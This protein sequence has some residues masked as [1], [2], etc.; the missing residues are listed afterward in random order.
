MSVVYR[1]AD[2]TYTEVD[3]FA[4][5][6]S[7]DHDGD[8]G[9]ANQAWPTYVWR[10]DGVVFVPPTVTGGNA[11]YIGT[12]AGFAAADVTGNGALDVYYSAS[13]SDLYHATDLDGDGDWMGTDESWQIWGS[14]S[15]RMND[16]ALVQ[17][18]LPDAEYK[19]GHWVLLQW[20]RS[21]SMS[22]ATRNLQIFTLDQN[23]DLVPGD[24]KIIASYYNGTGDQSLEVMGTSLGSSNSYIGFMPL[25]ALQVPEP[26]TML[27]VGSGILGLVGT[28]RRRFLH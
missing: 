5:R 3:M 21:T 11:N 18:A 8:P 4:D 26:G 9:T 10:E 25:N 15:A 13:A 6:P 12:T 1:H 24:Y 17:V 20:Q 7:W 14:T 27:L 28:L 19:A 23:G 22:Y 2:G 16:L